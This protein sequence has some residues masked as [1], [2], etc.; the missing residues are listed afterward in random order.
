M[1]SQD[2]AKESSGQMGLLGKKAGRRLTRLVNSQLGKLLKKLLKTFMQQVV[3][4]LGKSLLLLIGPWGIATLVAIL[5]FLAVLESIPGADWFLHGG[6]RDAQMLQIDKQY[7]DQF[8]SKANESVAVVDTYR[9]DPS[10]RREFTELIKP[11]W[12]LPAA[13]ARYNIMKAQTFQLTGASNPS[14]TPV[15]PPTNTGGKTEIHVVATGY[16]PD[17]A[18]CSGITVTGINA[19]AFPTPKIIAVDPRLIPLHSQV[20]LFDN[21]SSMGIFSAEDTGGDIKGNRI[22]I[23]YAS[24]DLSSYFG[25]RVLVA[26][27]LKW[28]GPAAPIGTWNA[29]AG[30][31]QMPDVESMFDQ[32]KPRFTYKTISNDVQRWKIVTTTCGK[33]GCTTTTNYQTQPWP[34]HQVLD[35]VWTYNGDIRVPS[36]KKYWTGMESDQDWRDN[37][38]S[39]NNNTYVLVNG[40]GETG[41]DLKRTGKK[42]KCKV[43]EGENSTTTLCTYY[44]HENTEV[45]DRSMPTYKIDSDRL[46]DILIGRGVKEVD[47]PIIYQFAAAADP[48]DKGNYF[49]AGQLKGV[50]VKSKFTDYANL[51]LPTDLEIG[52]EI[53][54]GWT[55]PIRG[56]QKITDV[57]GPRWG[58]FHY[59]VDLGGSAAL[60]YPIVAA[61]SGKVIRAEYSTSYGNVVYLL[62]PDGLETRYA[63][64]SSLTV[65][66]DQ[67]VTAGTQLGFEGAT[68]DASGPHLHF[69]V[70]K[71]GSRSPYSLTRDMERVYNPMIFLS[72][73]M[74]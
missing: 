34:S 50:N 26:R 4:G 25:R 56:S 28:G 63:H 38:G 59:G 68:G 3:I 40:V 22:D 65:Q 60:G 9:A 30:Q 54:N 53:K 27:I 31:V 49:Y 70:M 72:T 47:V 33:K 21:G 35:W 7:E 62:Q 66:Y 51:T 2:L 48:T 12:A 14:S 41:M 39:L 44:Q 45:D 42:G 43:T 57:F 5:V 24:E 64:M 67:N 36:L 58:T 10:W 74:K 23:L 1:S 69:E 52:G 6:A 55:W 73:L 32:L 61:H 17:C 8:R 29:L 19:R 71:P 16:G 11:S 46:H 20:E 37:Q 15:P 13:L 18:G